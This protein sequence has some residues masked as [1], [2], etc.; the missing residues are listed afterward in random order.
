MSP[1][2]RPRFASPLATGVFCC[3][4]ALDERRVSAAVSHYG[5]FLK[6]GSMS[7][8]RS[9]PRLLIPKINVLTDARRGEMPT[10]Y[11]TDRDRFPGDDLMTTDLGKARVW[12]F[13]PGVRRYVKRNLAALPILAKLRRVW[14]SH[15]I[16][17]AAQASAKPSEA[18]STLP[19]PTDLLPSIVQATAAAE[20]PKPARK[21]STS[22]KVNPN[23]ARGRTP[24]KRARQTHAKRSPTVKAR[25]PRPARKVA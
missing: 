9:S 20:S 25:T 14:V 16:V 6:G 21:R 3:A 11:L 19:P 17:L 22:A 2:T 1:L 5:F 7:K 12:A 8:L 10:R 23:K 15:S 18:A 13:A 4:P 24:G